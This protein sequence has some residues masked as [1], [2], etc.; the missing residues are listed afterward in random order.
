MSP[1]LESSL[2][3]ASV[4]LLVVLIGQVLV[5]I[6][7]ERHASKRDAQYLAIRIVCILD[8]YV[9]DCA[10]TA[11]DAGEENEQ[12][13]PIA[14]VDAPRA[15]AYPSDVNWKS[16]DATM[17]YRILSLPAAADRAANY[18]S[19]VS[20]HS[21]PPD[22]S[23]FFEARSLRYSR[24]GLEAHELTAA[25]RRK[26]GIQEIPNQSWDPVQAMKAELKAIDDRQKQ[27]AAA[28]AKLMPPAGS[29][30]A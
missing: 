1:T 28:W 23:E 27:S 10:S 25:L 9:E 14:Q 2:I 15:P 20:E 6:A 16:I 26:Y 17:M 19:G 22:C 11:T 24:L 13:I 30:P 5:P 3:S 7:R 21:D 18:V 29:E 12:G 8:Q 4:A